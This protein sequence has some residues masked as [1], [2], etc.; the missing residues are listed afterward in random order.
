M[1]RLCAH[2][3][4]TTLNPTNEYKAVSLFFCSLQSQK[5]ETLFLGH[6]FLLV[7]LK[8][9]IAVPPSKVE[10]TKVE[11]SLNL[12]RHFYIAFGSSKLEFTQI[13]INQF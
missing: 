10:V 5:Q 13:S 6:I 1:H 8:F 11:V 7:N 2:L 3:K 4:M 12:L 9:S